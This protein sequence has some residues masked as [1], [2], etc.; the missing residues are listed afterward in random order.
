MSD[1]LLKAAINSVSI[2][3]LSPSLSFLNIFSV[4]AKESGF[5]TNSFLQL[6][7]SAKTIKTQNL[8]IFIFF[9]LRNVRLIFN[10]SIT[11]TG[12]T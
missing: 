9:K 3:R 11:N 5:M 4:N 1:L 8:F 6:N 12:V 10:K 7:K 2:S